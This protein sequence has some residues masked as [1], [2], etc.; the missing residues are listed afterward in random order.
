MQVLANGVQIEIDVSGPALGEPLLL[1]MGLGMQLT[2]WPE[3][4]VAQL[5][6]QG[7]RV[8]RYDHRDIG[9]SQPLDELGHPNMPLAMMNRMLGLRVDAPYSLA[10]LADDAL[11]VLDAL[12]IE[13]AH[14]CGASMGGMVAQHLAV[15]QPERVRSLTLMMSSSGSPWLPS[16]DARVQMALVS[17][18]PGRHD[19][20]G[21]VAHF[22]Q[23][24]R[25]IGSPAYPEPEDSLTQR[26]AAWLARSYRPQAV[27]RQLLAVTADGDRSAMLAQIKVPTHIVQG[28]EDRLVR[29]AAGRDLA[30]RIRGAVLHEIAG[31]GHD[32]PAPLWPLFSQQ[33]AS[34][35]QRA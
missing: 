14:V 10:D 4:L 28:Q 31:M 16:V 15:R 25:M 20:A 5:V 1:I 21:L 12:G 34:L 2:D 23:L 27:A 22:V 9:L 19:D 17:T 26:V 3:G 11:G 29:A 30:K 24:N 33:M 7:F 18:P 6:A 32:L 8:L 35:A 13:R